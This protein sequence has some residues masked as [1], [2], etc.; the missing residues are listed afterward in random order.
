MT[1]EINPEVNQALLS[2]NHSRNG[3]KDP[4]DYVEIILQ[5]RQAQAMEMMLAGKT[6]GEIARQLG[7]TRQ[8]VNY[9]RNRDE[10]FKR[11]LSMRRLELWQAVKE[12][13]SAMH[14]EALAV[15]RKLLKSKDPKLQMK[16][17]AHIVNLHELK[18][19]LIN[20][21]RAYLKLIEN[22]K[23]IDQFFY[24]LERNKKRKN[25]EELTL[26][27]LTFEVDQREMEMRR[28]WR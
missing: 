28:R 24:W 14:T 17:A 2:L 19:N 11:V 5:P 7:V 8:T 25:P 9:W 15:L 12:E 13:M 18:D 21:N 23:R 26:D 6:D 22:M 16:A 10:D 1:I 4:R 3:D 27:E 20:E